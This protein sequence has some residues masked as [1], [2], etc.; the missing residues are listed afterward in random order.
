MKNFLIAILIIASSTICRSQT[1]DCDCSGP[2]SA[3]LKNKVN[4]VKYK[5]FKQW[6]YQYFEKSETDR[7]ASKSNN[8]FNLDA[9]FGAIV[10]AIPIKFE[11]GIGSSSSSESQ[12]YYTLY[13]QYMQQHYLSDEQ[14]N[15]IFTE[16]FSDNQLAGYKACLNLCSNSNSNGIFYNISDNTTDQFYITITFRSTSGGGKITFK[17]NAVYSNLEPIGGLVF[18]DNLVIKNGQS[19]I[20]FFK[21][22]DPYKIA[23]FGFS[24]KE[25]VTVNPIELEAT[26]KSQ[27]NMPIGMIVASVLSYDSFLDVNNVDSKD[28]GDMSKVTWIPCDGRFEGKSKYSKFSGGQIP[29]LRGLFLRGANSYG[30]D[31]PNVGLVADDHKNK[32]EKGIGIYQEDQYK[33][34]KHLIREAWGF[35]TD[36]GVEVPFVGSNQRP[37]SGEIG[38]VTETYRSSD[39]SD[40]ETR[41]KNVSVYYYIKIND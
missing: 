14:L 15:M 5:N 3:D 37:T 25:N 20:Q 12:R 1:K 32:D 36:R 6:L 40:N 8:E 29:D 26:K 17:G 22:I 18:K 16:V 11:L 10:K 33:N 23:S 39:G 31:F 34:H 7:Q 24:V 9:T 13:Q 38:S 30:V 35:R 27:N 28:R 41:P 21:R 2:L 19:A 4:E